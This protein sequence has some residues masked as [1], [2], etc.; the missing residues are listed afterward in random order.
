MAAQQRTGHQARAI[1]ALMVFAA[2]VQLS[3]PLMGSGLGSL[4]TST[5]CVGLL[6][7]A[8]LFR[9]TEQENGEA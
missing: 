6:G 2:L 4:V 8:I 7:A 1:A 9:N 5:F 3:T